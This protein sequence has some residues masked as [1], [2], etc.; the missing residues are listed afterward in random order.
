MRKKISHHSKMLQRRVDRVVALV[1]EVK[2]S[3][4]HHNS[5]ARKNAEPRMVSMYIQHKVLGISHPRICRYF[6]KRSSHSTSIAAIQTIAG[7]ICTEI[8]VRKRVNECIEMYQNYEVSKIKQRYNLHYRIRQSGVQVSAPNRTIYCT[9]H[10]Y[11]ALEGT[12]RER[13]N[14]LTKKHH[15]SIQL[16]IC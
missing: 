1:Y 15:Y 3:D 13:I 2:I 8:K 4:I 6:H 14:R 9:H 16:T 10:E 7:L 5:T 12:L 11:M